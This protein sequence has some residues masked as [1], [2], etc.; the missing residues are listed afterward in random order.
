MDRHLTLP[1]ILFGLFLI[2]LAVRLVALW[3]FPE[4]HLG[5]NAI[6]AYL[7]GAKLLVEG[8][9]FADP[10][11]PVFTPPLY[12][13]FIAAASYVFGSPELPI[14][15]AQAI[16]DSLTVVLTYLIASH[17]FGRATA[18]LSSVLL[19][20]YPFAVYPVTY[21]GTETFFTFFLSVFVLLSV[22]A[23]T[24]QD[25]RYYIGAGLFLGL[26]TLMRGTTQ[27]YPVF[28][29]ALLL[30]LHKVS[31]STVCRYL[32]FCLCFTLVIVPWT[33]RNYLI[34]GEFIPVA[35]ASA[36]FLQ[37]SSEEFF[38]ISGKDAAYPGYFAELRS[39]GI[40]EPVAGTVVEKDRFLFR[41]GLEKY[42]TR[43]ERDPASFG[44][45]LL[46]KF[47]RLWYATESG[48][49]HG[50]ILAMNLPI[51]LASLLG[52]ISAIRSRSTSCF[53]LLSIIGYMVFLHWV[54]LPLFRY[55]V[56]IMPYVIIFAAFGAVIVWEGLHKRL[57]AATT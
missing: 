13:V 33:L 16:A 37:G 12:A 32:V 1:R 47:L 21:I 4:R 11:F 24:Y 31:R 50:T 17:I 54:S 2:A 20:F 42:R 43:L 18:L 36:V 40:A 22:Y 6:I 3:A 14:K 28:W 34:L 45:F 25:T 38:T 7:G 57:F 48:K 27:F 26:A 39:R 10:S 46:K 49:S 19:I 35:T 9:G 8:R 5:T 44:P 55:I 53:H 52:I 56:P 29:L 15:I 51:Y 23:A 41:A 30:V